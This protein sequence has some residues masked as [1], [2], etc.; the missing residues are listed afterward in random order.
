MPVQ[1]TTY[2]QFLG[3]TIIPTIDGTDEF[4]FLFSAQEIR[5]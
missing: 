1:K 2:I 4:L 5:G 3:A